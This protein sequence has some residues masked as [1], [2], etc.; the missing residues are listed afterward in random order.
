MRQVQ[1]FIPFILLTLISIP[2]WAVAQDA[3]TILKRVRYQQTA[4]EVKLRGKLRVDRET[5][6]F[7]LTWD[8]GVMRYDFKLPA[9]AYLF[10]FGNSGAN[11]TEITR[12]GRDS[13]GRGRRDEELY[14]SGMTFEDLALEFLY[15]NNAQLLGD[16]FLRTRNVWKIR[17]RPG[18]R[19]SSYAEVILW[20]DKKTYALMRVE[21][22]DRAGRLL[23][24][25]E[26]LEVQQL[27]ETWALK[28]MRMEAYDPARGRVRQRSYLEIEGS[29]R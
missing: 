6:P 15:W 18:N 7:V 10:R 17:V 22:Y 20:V 25:M 16:D 2:S 24:K 8:G 13:I 23:K 19:Q 29:A 4:N 27:P 26:V 14:D 5:H 3:D 21:G 12:M 9:K 1:K 11:I 28:R